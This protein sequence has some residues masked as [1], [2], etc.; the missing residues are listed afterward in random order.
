MST[1]MVIAVNA[2]ILVS[3]DIFIAGIRFYTGNRGY[4]CELGLISVISCTYKCLSRKLF[5]NIFILQI[6]E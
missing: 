6:Y 1:V 3:L 4:R 5:L 2:P